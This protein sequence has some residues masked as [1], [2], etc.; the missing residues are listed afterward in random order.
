M[1]ILLLELGD[2][3]QPDAISLGDAHPLTGTSTSNLPAWPG[4]HH[5]YP[6]PIRPV[7]QD[8]EDVSHVQLAVTL[9][10]I[11][12]V[13]VTGESDLLDL[14]VYLCSLAWKFRD[15]VSPDQSTDVESLPG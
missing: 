5:V 3:H 10:E 2:V 11:A 8:E 1:K 14:L 7:G 12:P 13:G 9:R 15:V 4:N 6:L